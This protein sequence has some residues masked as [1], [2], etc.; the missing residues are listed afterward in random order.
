M[1]C[2]CQRCG[3]EY[4]YS[5]TSGHSTKKCNSC[6]VNTRRFKLKEK[7]V[8]LLGG[9][10]YDCGYNECFRAFDIH[11]LYGKDFNISGNHSRKWSILEEE[12]KKCILLCANCHRKRHCNL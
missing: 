5:K 10:C 8:I 12:L 9:E 4:I 2:T 3:R 11:H 6:I 1:N 7:I